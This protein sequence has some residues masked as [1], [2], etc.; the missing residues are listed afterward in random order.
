MAEYPWGQWEYQA[1][2]EEN[3]EKARTAMEA[4]VAATVKAFFRKGNP[5]A[6]GK[7][8]RTARIRRDGDWFGGLGKAPPLPLDRDVLSEEDLSKYVSAL[9][10]NGFFGPCSWYMNHARNLEYATKRPRRRQA[11]HA[12]PLPPRR[13]RL[14]L[15]DDDLSPR[16]PH[17]RATART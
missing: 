10:A 17:A 11:A 9:E 4:D 3:F 7:P 6:K 16:G 13:L 14:H 8:A 5:D 12:R 1:F 15:R 2:Y